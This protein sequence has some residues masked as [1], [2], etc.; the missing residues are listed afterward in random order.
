MK[1]SYFSIPVLVSL[2]TGKS[3]PVNLKVELG[4]EIGLNI[5]SSV[6][7]SND[8]LTTVLS[9]KQTGVG[10]AYGAGFGFM[11]NPDHTIRFDLG[12]RGVYGSKIKTNAAYFGFTFLF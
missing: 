9:T 8:T 12:Y 2:N 1:V 10:I 7:S 5:G 11:L 3:N 6:K 4:P